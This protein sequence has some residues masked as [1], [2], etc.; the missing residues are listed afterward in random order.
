MTSAMLSPWQLALRIGLFTALTTFGV[1]GCGPAVEY[2]YPKNIQGFVLPPGC[3]SGSAPADTTQLRA[4]LTGIDFDTTEFVGD[5]QRLMV[6][7]DSGSG[8]GAL[9]FGDSTHVC[10]HGPLARV[11]PVKG[12]ELYSDSALAEGRI[13]ARIYLRTGETESYDKF[14]LVPGDTTYWWVNA[15]Q[16]SSLFVHRAGMGP[17]LAVTRRGLT[18]TY[19]PHG[20]FQQ[21]F[22]QWVWDPTDETLNGGCGSHCCKP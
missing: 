14:G 10:R 9:C 5:E 3:P 7:S 19:H 17:D 8:P 21:A 13:I 18:M 11:D 2:V 20:S 6:R 4:C 1:I 22:A 15:A 16:D 12:S